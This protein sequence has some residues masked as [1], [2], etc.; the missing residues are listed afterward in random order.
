MPLHLK[1]LFSLTRFFHIKPNL[2]CWAAGRFFEKD[3]DSYFLKSQGLSIICK[4]K[5]P[6]PKNIKEGAWIA[7]QLISQKKIRRIQSLKTAHSFESAQF[8]PAGKGAEE[9][10]YTARRKNL[11]GKDTVNSQT[12]YLTG[13][14]RLLRNP[15]NIYIEKDFSY[16]KKGQVLQTWQI[17]LRGVEDF[18]INKGLSFAKTPHLVKCPGTEPHLKALQSSY[19]NYYLATSPEMHLKKLLCQDWTDFFEIKACFREEE[20]NSIHQI[21]FSLLEWYRAFYSL[22]DLMDELYELLLFLQKKDFCKIEEIPPAE[23]LSVSELFQTHL[24][25]SLTPQTS[26]QELLDLAEKQGLFASS[27]FNFEEL[28]FLL[29]LNKIELSICKKKPLFIYNY[30]PQLR[31]FAQINKEG[32]ADRFEFYWSGLELAN[33]F[34]EVID[35]NDQERLFQK[36]LQQRKDEVPLDK[37]LLKVMKGAMPPSCGAALGLDRLFL[38]LIGETDLRATRLFPL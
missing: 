32:W 27:S 6:L 1:S 9:A 21:E 38:A 28:F 14:C 25:F 4:K 23:F 20:S 18:F 31:A 15:D 16:N 10:V 30:P 37:E 12:V 35:S 22:K 13:E 34:Y 5:S 24:Q 36:H 33:A 11:R 17:F 8:K 19:Q 2:P 26:R 3:S 7:V 29:F